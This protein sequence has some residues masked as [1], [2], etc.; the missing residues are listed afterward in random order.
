MSTIA[1]IIKYKK[2]HPYP[3]QDIVLKPMSNFDE[4]PSD[5]EDYAL[6]CL[7]GRR[8]TAYRIPPHIALNVDSILNM[9]L[10]RVVEKYPQINIYNGEPEVQSPRDSVHKEEI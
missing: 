6:I 7:I 8:W 2:E 1:E 4:F 3:D 5:C 10:E 9:A